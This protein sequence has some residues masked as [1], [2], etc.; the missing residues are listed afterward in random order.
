MFR[1]YI[2]GGGWGR[3]G[4]LSV[5]MRGIKSKSVDLRLALREPEQSTVDEASIQVAGSCSNG[6][7]SKLC[8]ALGSRLYL[9]VQKWDPNCG[10]YPNT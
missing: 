5:A 2:K 7:F 3:E 4:G 8:A 10:N 6:L 1:V 9:G